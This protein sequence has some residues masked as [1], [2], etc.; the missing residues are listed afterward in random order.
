MQLIML[1]DDMLQSR[2]I[3]TN[4]YLT[5]KKN[6]NHISRPCNEWRG[7]LKKN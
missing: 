6:L 4:F 2:F 5:S 3:N 1:N 7:E